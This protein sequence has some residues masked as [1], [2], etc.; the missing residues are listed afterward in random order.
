MQQD[1]DET[2]IGALWEEALFKYKRDTNRD[3][4]M[5]PRQSW[6]VAAM[7]EEQ[8]TQV[9]AFTNWRHNKGLVDKLRT[10]IARNSKIIQGVA[11]LLADAA[12]AVRDC[13]IQPR[14]DLSLKR[15]SHS[16]PALRS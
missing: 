16:H 1:Q 2:D 7:M 13:S 3:L 10:V 4:L 14:L 5:L 11:Q 9:D 15:P 12:S 6:N 8:K